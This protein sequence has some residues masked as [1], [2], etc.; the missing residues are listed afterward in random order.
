MPPTDQ[1]SFALIGFGL[2]LVGM[3]VASG[4]IWVSGGDYRPRKRWEFDTMADL[5][6]ATPESIKAKL[7]TALQAKRDLDEAPAR[8]QKALADALADLRAEEDAFFSASA[9]RP[10]AK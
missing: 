1:Q 7:L 9:P 8:L 6:A 2:F 5:I 10:E 4:M 3:A